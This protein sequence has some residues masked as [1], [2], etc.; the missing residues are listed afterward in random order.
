MKGVPSDEE[1]SAMTHEERVLLMKR[2]RGRGYGLFS[3][4]FGTIAGLT[5]G[6]WSSIG[7]GAIGVGV[8]ASMGILCAGRLSLSA[9]NK[10]NEVDMKIMGGGIVEA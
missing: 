9:A 8:G 6:L 1:L 5:G 3:A 7:W 10:I 4:A 2:F